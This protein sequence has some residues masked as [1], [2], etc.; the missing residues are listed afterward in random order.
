LRLAGLTSLILLFFLFFPGD[1][2][3]GIIELS[4]SFSYSSATYGTTGAQTRRSWEGSVGY[5]LYDLTEIQG[6]VEEVHDH[7]VISGVGETTFRDQIYSIEVLQALLPRRVGFQPFLKVGAGQ[8]IRE[9]SGV[10]GGTPIN[11]IETGS[12]TGIL[13]G[14]VRFFLHRQF[15]LKVEGTSYL[16]NARLASWRTNFGLRVGFSFYF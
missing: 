6:A 13:G 3:A 1:A 14:G 15:S 9:A 11:P 10:Y 5:Y 12:L 16:S 4:A 2:K 7:S 8:L